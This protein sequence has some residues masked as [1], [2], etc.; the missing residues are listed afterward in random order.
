M[1][2]LVYSTKRQCTTY[3]TIKYLLTDQ[4]DLTKKSNIFGFTT[5]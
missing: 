5:R 3:I 1:T 2:S 4:K